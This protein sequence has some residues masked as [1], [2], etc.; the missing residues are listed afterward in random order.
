M[1][2]NTSDN[3]DPA[4]I[5]SRML[6]TD[7]LENKPDW[8]G[9]SCAGDSVAEFILNISRMP[10]SVYRTSRRHDECPGSRFSPQIRLPTGNAA[11]ESFF[12]LHLLRVTCQAR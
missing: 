1:I 12:R 10:T 11:Q 2:V 8:F 4:R 6:R 3:S 5:N 9:S 7:S